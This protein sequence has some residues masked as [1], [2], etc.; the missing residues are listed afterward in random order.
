M[1]YSMEFKYEALL[2]RAREKLPIKVSATQE[3]FEVPKVLW[4]I[5]GVK[6]IISNFG[7]ICT[8]FNRPQEHLLKYLQRELATPANIDGPRLIMGRK[9]QAEAINNKLVQYANDFVICKVCKKP[10]TKLIKEDRI[11]YM[12]CMACGAKNPIKAKI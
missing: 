10:D 11:T 1:I 7:N 12:H 3:R 5:Q 9:L 8:I 2:K 4:L 6:T